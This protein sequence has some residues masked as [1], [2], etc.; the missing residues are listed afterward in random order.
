[1]AATPRFDPVAQSPL[2]FEPVADDEFTALLLG[3]RA[4]TT[5]GAAP[6][7]FNAANEE[8]V[9]LFLAGRLRFP[10]IVEAIESAMD[11]LDSM[12]SATRED[13]LLADSKARAHVSERFGR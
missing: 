10:Q 13:L 6:A 5:G 7:V 9:A 4:G 11:E 2:T 3:F 12:P 8:A 1:D